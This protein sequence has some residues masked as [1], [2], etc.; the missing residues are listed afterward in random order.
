MLV[1]PYTLTRTLRSMPVPRTRRSPRQSCP[2][3]SEW[4][5]IR[6]LLAP[7]CPS[8]TTLPSSGCRC[9]SPAIEGRD[10]RWSVP[11]F[12][13]PWLRQPHPVVQQNPPP[14]PAPPPSLWKGRCGLMSQ[15]SGCGLSFPNCLLLVACFSFLFPF[16]VGFQFQ[17]FQVF[18]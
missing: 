16:C 10:R 1:P 9:P 3:E 11:L 17:L 13:P 14:P 4:D 2:P 5:S 6:P 7:G 15:L 8:A 12:L 18:G